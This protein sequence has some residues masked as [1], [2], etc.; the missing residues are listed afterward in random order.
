V[1]PRS[2]VPPELPEWLK[3]A[4][5]CG[6]VHG[7][8]AKGMGVSDEAHARLCNRCT[9]RRESARLVLEGLAQEMDQWL[10]IHWA[11]RCRE[12]ASTLEGS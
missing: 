3:Q 1:S 2:V 10:Q 7:G 9:E 4:I 8:W 12:L 11:M 6:Y 5:Y